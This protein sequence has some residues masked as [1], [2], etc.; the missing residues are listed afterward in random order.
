M[1]KITF[2]TYSIR[3]DNSL[4]AIVRKSNKKILIFSCP[5]LYL[6]SSYKI[7]SQLCSVSLLCTP[8]SV[9]S[10]Y[11]NYYILFIEAELFPYRRRVRVAHTSRGTTGTAGNC[12]CGYVR[13]GRY[14]TR[15]N[16]TLE[17]ILH[18]RLYYYHV[19]LGRSSIDFPEK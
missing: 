14:R 11:V 17:V 10:F 6:L 16:V 2:T 13:S 3:E 1:I 12:Y 19:P 7:T 4:S 5:C 9:R 8:S 18:Y 15:Y